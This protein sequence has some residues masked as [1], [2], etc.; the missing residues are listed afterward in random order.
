MKLEQRAT[1][2]FRRS[3]S[4]G[5]LKV[6]TAH[7]SRPIDPADRWRHG[8][9]KPIAQ[10]EKEMNLETFQAVITALE[11]RLGSQE[12]LQQELDQ[13]RHWYAE[14]QRAKSELLGKIETLQE[15]TAAQRAKSDKFHDLLQAEAG[16]LQSTVKDRDDEIMR[17]S[18]EL[19]EYMGL[20]EALEG[21]IK[22]LEFKQEQQEAALSNVAMLEG[23]VHS[24]NA[25]TKQ[26]QDNFGSLTEEFQVKL[27]H[28]QRAL[29]EEM[30]KCTQLL[31]ENDQ[32]R[33]M[34]R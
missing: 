13:L 26:A 25:A 4:G 9:E 32:L 5:A 20:N 16:N 33:E 11:Q 22:E 15:K 3:S 19:R 14:E 7:A 23:Q 30:E 24:L 28:H 17:I 21:K 12:D 6:P 34:N 10:I 2:A 8:G 31:R 29:G 27:S 1:K 18:D